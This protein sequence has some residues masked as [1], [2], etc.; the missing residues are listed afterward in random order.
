MRLREWPGLCHPGHIDDFCLKLL[1]HLPKDKS[2]KLADVMGTKPGTSV[3]NI[4]DLSVGNAVS[5][6]QQRSAVNVDKKT[7]S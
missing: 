3:R 4:G 5:H 7:A 6:Q 1:P 2:V